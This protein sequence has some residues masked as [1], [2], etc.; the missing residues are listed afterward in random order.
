VSYLGAVGIR[1][2][3][4]AL[5]RAAFG[6]HAREKKATGLLQLQ[7]GSFGNAVT[8]IERH[9]VSDGDLA[10]GSYAEIDELFR[11]QAPEPDRGKREALL[12][13]IQ[14]IAYERVMFVPIWQVAQLNGVRTR[15][16]EPGIGLI[17]YLP[18]SAPYED[19]RIR[20]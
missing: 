6:V 12:H 15:I 7:S 14:R 20:P 5:E 9:M 2:R 4:R 3:V 10:F 1:A 11:Q 16:D 18:Y 8:R 17:D 19:L 13:A